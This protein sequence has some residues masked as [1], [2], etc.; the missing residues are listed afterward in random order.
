MV[1][2]EAFSAKQLSPFMVEKEQEIGQDDPGCPTAKG[3]DEGWPEEI[4]P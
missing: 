2:S 1:T 4:Q 3:H